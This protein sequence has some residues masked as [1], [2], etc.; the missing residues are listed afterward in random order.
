MHIDTGDTA[1]ILLCTALIFFMVPGLALF[2]GGLVRSK[3]VVTTMVQCFVSVAVVGVVWVVIGYTLVFG[4]DRG[5]VI[6]SLAHTMLTDVG[7]TPTSAAPAVP[8]LAFMA[9]QMMFAVITPALIAG[10]FA[11]RMTFRGYV[12]FTGL[13]SLVVYVPLA[14]WEWGGGFL[15]SHGLGALDFAGGAVIHESAGA[16][17]LAAAIYFGRRKKPVTR[18]YNVPMV[19]LGAGI[20]WFGWFGFN[21]GS[22]LSAGHVAVSAVVNTQLGASAG[23]IVWMIVDWARGGKPS[24]VGIATGAIAGL[25]AITPAAGYVAPWAALVIGASAGLVCHLAV[26]L[27][28]RLRYDDVL[29]VVGVHMVG[30][31]IGV[32]LTGVFASLAV[33]AAGAAGGWAQLGRQ[34]VLAVVALAYPFVMT[35]LLLWITDHAVGLRVAP[36]DEEKGLDLSQLLDPVSDGPTGPI[37]WRPCQATLGDPRL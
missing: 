11:E 34:S 21:G 19:L 13:W 30:G 36:G 23:L 1:W 27:K 10:A 8:A 7:A 32:L 16:A 2:Y 33:N 24:G 5:G 4:A 28:K 18:P 25:A 26:R 14:H 3:N 15:G 17:A 29:D 31:F 9:F 35:M 20:L 37:P 6:G 22:A 12:M